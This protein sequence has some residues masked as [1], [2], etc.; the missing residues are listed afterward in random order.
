MP[1]IQG[2]NH[3]YML[4]SPG[5]L[6]LYSEVAPGVTA[7][8]APLRRIGIMWAATP[9]SILAAPYDRRQRQPVA[10]HL[11]ALCL[12]L[13][14]GM[15]S[16]KASAPRGRMSQTLLLPLGLT[17]W[18]HLPPPASLGAVTAVD[19]RRATG[20]AGHAAAVRAGRPTTSTDWSLRRGSA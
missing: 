2:P 1:E 12:L 17:G 16:E 9:S 20:R 18:P 13:K 8:P 5:C 7:P 4:T 11:T 19:V 3:A 15:S 14:H 6:R 10:V